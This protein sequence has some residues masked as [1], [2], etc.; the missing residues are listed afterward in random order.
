MDR[1]NI[2][3]LAL[4]VVLPTVG[5]SQ[6]RTEEQPGLELLLQPEEV[7]GGVPETFTFV[8]VNRSNNESPCHPLSAKTPH[9][10]GVFV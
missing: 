5:I 2:L 1:L 7:Q 10:T 8:L 4:A 3:V 9:S 6:P